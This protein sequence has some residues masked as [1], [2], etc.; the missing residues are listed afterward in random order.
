[1]P[2]QNANKSD[3]VISITRYLYD[4]DHIWSLYWYKSDILKLCFIQNKNIL[5]FLEI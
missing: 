5:T 3:I 2:I 1:M 4:I